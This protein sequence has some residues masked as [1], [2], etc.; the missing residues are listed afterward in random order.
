[1]V[2]REAE[3]ADGLRVDRWLAARFT[4]RSRS[5]WRGCV[6]RGLIKL[7][8]RAVRPSRAL[9]PGDTVEFITEDFE[10][11]EVNFSYRIIWQD[12]HL[13]AV[14]KPANLPCHPAG[15]FFKNTLW[16]R[17]SSDFG[18]ELF[19]VNRLDR[20]TS[21]V[22]LFAKSE[23]MA[24]RMSSVLSGDLV[25][26]EYL[27]IVHGEF[28]DAVDAAG[29]LIGDESSPVRK[30]RRFV[31]EGEA[32][33]IIDPAR[34]DVE[35][36]ST[37]FRRTMFACGLSAVRATLGTGRTHQIRATLLSLG[38]PVVG[39]KIYGVDDGIYLRFIEGSTT[40]DDWNRMLIPR[41]AL[42]SRMM[43][44]PHPLDGVRIVVEAPL[45]KDMEG[46]IIY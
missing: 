23:E 9:R 11:P 28:P 35:T 25:E 18:R 2:G 27:A 29:Y 24:G 39:D 16:H 1:M 26:K 37:F 13:I 43:S 31:P 21:G 45:P 14:D 19:L 3:G 22:I 17:L 38:F 5:Q 4:Y 30:K 44:F 42:H 8:G 34:R 6:E 12:A 40:P 36:S 33:K 7:N 15:P 10:E 41:Q 32:G 46:L 20:E